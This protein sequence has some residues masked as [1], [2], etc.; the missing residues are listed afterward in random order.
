MWWKFVRRRAMMTGEACSPVSPGACCI[1]LQTCDEGPR[2][3]M[4]PRPPGRE[5]LAALMEERRMELGLTW[6][7]VADA[8][9]IRYE[10]LRAVRN[11]DGSIRPLT[12]RAIATA[13]RWSPGSVDLILAGAD[14]EPAPERAVP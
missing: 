1:L 14:P 13:L 10:T 7:Q 11:R 9:G 3:Q 6:E 5:R 8:A 2:T 4:P 12:R